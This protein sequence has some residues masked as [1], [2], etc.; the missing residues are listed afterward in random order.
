MLLCKLPEKMRQLKFGTIV[1]VQIDDYGPKF[2]LMRSEDF[3]KLAELAGALMK[4]R[5]L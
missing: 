2:V 3:E 4:E 1:E 5:A